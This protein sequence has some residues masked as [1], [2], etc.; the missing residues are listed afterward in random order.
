LEL[1]SAQE[2]KLLQKKEARSILGVKVQVGVSCF[3]MRCLRRLKEMKAA[4]FGQQQ[5]ILKDPESQ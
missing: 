3:A 1:I 2:I 5:T 4:G